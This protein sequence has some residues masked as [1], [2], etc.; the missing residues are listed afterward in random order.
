MGRPIEFDRTDVLEKALQVFWRK[1][2]ASTSMQ[3]LVAATGINKAS[4]YNSFGDKEA[5]FICVLEHYFESRSRPR[6]RKL[7]ETSPA[8][9]GIHG[10]FDSLVAISMSEAYGLGCLIT[11]TAAE[12]QPTSERI[13]ASIQ[14]ALNMMEGL[15]LDTIIRGREDGS[16]TSD[17]PPVALARTLLGVVQAVRVLARARRSEDMLRD[18]VDT[19]LSLLDRTTAGGARAQSVMA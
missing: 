1:G 17:I 4:I 15:F 7:V 16:I 18:I 13:E 8:R 19:S 9:D 10:Y 14:R 12:L 6:A 11:N 2:Y 5:F 3:D